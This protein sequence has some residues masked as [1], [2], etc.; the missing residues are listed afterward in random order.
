M[1]GYLDCVS[2]LAYEP[3]YKSDLLIGDKKLTISQ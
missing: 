3:K 2:N 1:L